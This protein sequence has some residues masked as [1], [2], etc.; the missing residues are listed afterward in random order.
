MGTAVYNTLT[1]EYAGPAS[2]S[3]YNSIAGKASFDALAMQLLFYD[4]IICLSDNLA[5]VPMLAEMVGL[6]Y[7]I[8]ALRRGELQFLRSREVVGMQDGKIVFITKNRDGTARFGPSNWPKAAFGRELPEAAAWVARIG[9]RYLDEPQ[10]QN[11]KDAIIGATIDVARESIPVA[12]FDGLDAEVADLNESIIQTGGHRSDVVRLEHEEGWPRV[13]VPSEAVDRN[14]LERSVLDIVAL[15][16]DLIV[17]SLA[18]LDGVASG[19]PPHLCMPCCDSRFRSLV[20]GGTGVSRGFLDEAD[21]RVLHEVAK[22][23]QV[24]SVGQLLREGNMIPS[25][26]VEIRESNAGKRLRAWFADNATDDPTSA[27]VEAR[28]LV[29]SRAKGSVRARAIDLLLSCALGTL[30]NAGANAMR[31]TAPV[32]LA[33]GVVAGTLSWWRGRVVGKL[34]CDRGHPLTIV[35]RLRLAESTDA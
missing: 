26:L 20:P 12:V 9:F 13:V 34:L 7:L 35:E 16:H 22:A 30:L 11:L 6:E 25:L 4:R 18:L 24:P 23:L 21:M 32:G 3:E 29:A 5:I 15:R 19:R 10:V 31:L 2:D 14:H 1:N 17:P 8:E 28:E 33:A 27:A